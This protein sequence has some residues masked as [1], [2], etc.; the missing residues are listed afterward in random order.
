MICSYRDQYS[1]L[2]EAIAEE[3]E[4]LLVREQAQE[5]VGFLQ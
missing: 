1:M 2:A 4:A 5:K 3:K